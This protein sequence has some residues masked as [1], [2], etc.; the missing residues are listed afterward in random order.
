MKLHE[1]NLYKLHSN[2][3]TLSGYEKRHLIGP[4]L[5]YGTENVVK[6]RWPEGEVVIS[7][8]RE[9]AREDRRFLKRLTQT[10]G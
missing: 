2:P 6:D 7:K 8:D 3:E 4:E 5:A 10:S 9:W 1:M